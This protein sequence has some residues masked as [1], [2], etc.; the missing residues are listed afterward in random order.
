MPFLTINGVPVAIATGSAQLQT[1]VM[2]DRARAFDGTLRSTQQ[3][4]KRRWQVTTAPLPPAESNALQRT[5]VPGDPYGAPLAC[6]GD[7]L[8][9]EVEC[10]AE[11]GSVSFVGVAGGHRQAVEFT[12]IEV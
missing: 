11:L 9:G 2:G 4:F 7:M 5:L 3:G 10:E 6:A 12:L 1:E 8:G